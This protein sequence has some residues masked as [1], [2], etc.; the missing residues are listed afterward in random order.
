MRLSM[1]LLEILEQFRQVCSLF[2]KFL[3]KAEREN[4]SDSAKE[5][6]DQD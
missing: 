1:L 6:K 2:D 3:E 4:Q 5:D